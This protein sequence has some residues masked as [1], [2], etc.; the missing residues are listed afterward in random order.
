[1]EIESETEEEQE[2][3]KQISDYETGGPTDF[4]DYVADEYEGPDIYG[5]TLEEDIS[6]D[7]MEKGG[8]KATITEGIGEE[9]SVCNNAANFERPICY[10]YCFSQGITSYCRSYLDKNRF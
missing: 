2:L 3:E 7:D 10:N 1:M 4:S 9:Q 8:T 6:K 5:A